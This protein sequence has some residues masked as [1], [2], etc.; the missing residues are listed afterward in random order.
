MFILEFE[1]I[2]LQKLDILLDHL[3][4]SQLSDSL[5]VFHEQLLAD[6]GLVYEECWNNLIEL[7]VELITI[8]SLFLPNQYFKTV[9]SA[10]PVELKLLRFEVKSEGVNH[11]L[12]ILKVQNVD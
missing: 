2:D 1:D 9:L 12:G 8:E 11:L 6:F 3:G 10:C 4:C 7:I 5:G